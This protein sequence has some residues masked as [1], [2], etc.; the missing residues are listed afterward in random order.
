MTT[1]F[2][3]HP[4]LHTTLLALVL[5]H[6]CLLPAAHAQPEADAR[7]AAQARALVASQEPQAALDLLARR[8]AASAPGFDVLF[9]KGLALQSLAT[10]TAPSAERG[11]MAR[12]AESA[13]KQALE[14][15]PGSAAV[16]NNLGALAASAGHDSDAGHW[17]E[18]AV[19]EGGARRAYYA[20]NYARHLE[21]RDPQAAQRYASMALEGAPQSDEARELLARLLARPGAPADGLLR[22]LED[23]VRQGR[24]RFA[25]STALRELVQPA[26]PRPA[27]DRAALLTAVALA[28]AGDRSVLAAATPPDYLAELRKVD[29]Q[30]GLGGGRRQL[31]A[32]LFAPPASARELDW[33]RSSASL[34]A[35][36]Q[37][38]HAVMLK[39]LRG[40]GEQQLPR[41]PEK[42]ERWLRLAVEFGERGPDPD[43]FLR[44]VELYVNTRQ[45]PRVRELMDRYQ[46]E[47]FSE[48]SA[49][50]GRNDWA[51]IYRLHLALGMTYA[52]MGV[53][54]SSNSPY[55]NAV[56]QLENAGRAAERFNRGAEQKNQPER[57]ALPAVATLKLSQGYV[58]LGQPTRATE[59][60]IK[61]AGTLQDLKRGPESAD[62]LRSIDEAELRRLPAVQVQQYERLKNALPR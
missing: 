59:A 29:E 3:S 60:K 17:Y 21:T 47:L 2:T 39:L 57:L 20:L 14:L 51:Q 55:Q 44:L 1:L 28:V 10:T 32:V 40:L 19:G 54:Q 26:E 36:T 24:T 30:P 6:Y 38:R 43:A 9:A 16:L 37:T 22:L 5:L 62:L 33:W 15:R 23:S 53:W 46:W 56:F 7:L 11:S 52:H 25:A 41:Q 31:E 58:A 13:Y 34:P 50:Y 35:L 42:A 12:E 48:K 18:R 27:T 61:A 4:A 45:E 8:E 49:A